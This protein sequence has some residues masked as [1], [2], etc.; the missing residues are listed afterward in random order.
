MRPPL[1]RKLTSRPLVLDAV[2]VGLHPRQL[3]AQPHD[4]AVEFARCAPAIPARGPQA[5]ACYARILAPVQVRPGNQLRSK[6]RRALLRLGR[7]CEGLPQDSEAETTVIAGHL[8][9]CR[10]RSLESS[11]DGPQAVL[12]KLKYLDVLRKVRASLG[13]ID[14][15]V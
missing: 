3:L 6:Y 13:R 7:E 14:Y 11:R 15:V 9:I 5:R 12:S 4:L 10:P 8:V 2:T 1:G